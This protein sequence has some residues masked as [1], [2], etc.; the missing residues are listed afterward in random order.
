MAALLNIQDMHRLIEQ[1]IQKM[2]FFAYDDL[3]SEE[4][5]LQINNQIYEFIEAVLAVY[6]GQKP[7][8]GVPEGFQADQVSLDS[9][10]TIHVREELRPLNSVTG[11]GKRFDLPD[12]YLHHVKTKL[13]V[14]YSCVENKQ[15]V[16]K[17]VSPKPALRVAESQNIDIMKASSFYKSKK[18]SPLGE[19]VGNRVF[20]YENGFTVTEAYLDYITRPAKVVYAKDINGDYT[21]VGS[22]DCNLP[23]SVHY[24]IV[25][26][27]AIKISKIIET[28][29]Q[30]IVNLEN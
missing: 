3:E 9:L 24:T 15:T 12:N 1:E 7:K 26:M 14:T 23:D 16:I 18:E 27:T 30:K 25:N 28:P 5:D 22:V 10:R 21:S 19:I 2:G 6:R 11:E 8:I 13:T 20:I 29:Q 17:T 4:I